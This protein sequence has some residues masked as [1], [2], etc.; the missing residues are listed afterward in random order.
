VI[1][2]NAAVAL[3]VSSVLVYGALTVGRVTAAV[4]MAAIIT[5]PYVLAQEAL[6]NLEDE[7]C[8]RAAGLKTI[9]TYLGINV[10]ITFIRTVLAFTMAIAL[11]PWFF[12]LASSIYLEA[13]TVCIL[14]PIALM[15]F[16]LRTPISWSAVGNT[17]K[18]S[19]LIWVTSLLPF[20]LLK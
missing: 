13:L 1:L 16:Y 18:L 5:F 7:E 9:A 4:W 20:A 19:R 15:I 6:F 8:D 11:A 10:A 3:L 2:G 17:V 14:A 12:G